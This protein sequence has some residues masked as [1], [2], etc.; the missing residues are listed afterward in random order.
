MVR[1]GDGRNKT[2]QKLKVKILRA[3]KYNGEFVAPGQEVEMN[4]ER[5]A[6][7]MR[8]GDIERNEELISK[9]KAQREAAA[10]AAIADARKDW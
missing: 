6:N 8:A 9:I 1:P 2:M 5:A 10:T 4:E 7:H 3:F